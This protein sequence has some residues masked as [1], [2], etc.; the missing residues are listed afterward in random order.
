MKKIHFI[1]A[2]I[3]ALALLQGCTE[4]VHDPVFA[5]SEFYIHADSWAKSTTV[6][7]GKN[8]VWEVFVSPADGSVKCRWTLDGEVVSNHTSVTLSFNRTGEHELVFTAERNG[9]V[10]TRT[11]AITVSAPDPVTEN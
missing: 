6:K 9:A 10:K 1:I 2:G 3:S 8:R 11:T 4:K 5:E 7:Q